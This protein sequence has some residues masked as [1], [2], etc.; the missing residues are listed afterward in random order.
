MLSP[1]LEYKVNPVFNV[2][3]SDFI[4]TDKAPLSCGS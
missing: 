2:Y 1:N 4:C 3:L